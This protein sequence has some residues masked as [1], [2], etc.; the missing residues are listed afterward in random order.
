MYRVKSWYCSLQKKNLGLVFEISYELPSQACSLTLLLIKGNCVSSFTQDPPLDYAKRNNRSTVFRIVP[1]FKKEK[2]QK[3]KTSPQPGTCVEITRTVVVFG[4]TR[5]LVTFFP[6]R[7]HD[8][9]SLR[10]KSKWKAAELS[11]IFVRM[12]ISFSAFRKH[13]LRPHD[14]QVNQRTT[15]KTFSFIMQQDLC[16]CWWLHLINSLSF[17]EAPIQVSFRCAIGLITL[18]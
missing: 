18:V 1:K 8:V 14:F 11:G 15:A 5:F 12:E 7:F 6:K 13:S 4:R 2:V 10:V 16:L 9:F 3:H 17:C